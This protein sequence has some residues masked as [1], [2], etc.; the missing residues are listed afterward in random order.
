[1]KD[2]TTSNIDRQNILNNNEVLETVQDHLGVSG[3]YF[4]EEYRFTKN[5]ISD[6]YQI[7]IATIDRYLEGN[8]NELKNNGYVVIKGKTL[9]EFKDQFGVVA[10]LSNKTP[11]LGLFNR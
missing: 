4:K 3:M 6:F 8:E 5:Q 1:M 2:L 7:D 10:N 11:Q 9:K